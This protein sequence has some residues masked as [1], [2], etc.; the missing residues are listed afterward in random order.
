LKYNSREI[1][2]NLRIQEK[3]DTGIFGIADPVV[4]EKV[5]KD[6]WVI[7]I[8]FGKAFAVGACAVKCNFVDRKLSPMEKVRNLAI[9][10]NALNEPYRKYKN[11]IT[12]L[13]IS[14]SHYI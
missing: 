7:G 12:I 5:K 10:T 14:R 1:I 11:E 6:C 4:V 2:K 3:K 9:K 8:D 13:E